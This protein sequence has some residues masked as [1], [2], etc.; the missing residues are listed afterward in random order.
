MYP[1][2]VDV[3][4]RAHWHIGKLG[5]FPVQ[6]PEVLEEE[7]F[8]RGKIHTKLLQDYS[9]YGSNMAGWQK[10]RHLTAVFTKILTAPTR[11]TRTPP[12]NHT[13]NLTLHVACYVTCNIKF[14]L[15]GN[16]KNYL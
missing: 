15:T 10:T 11:Q 14:L 12:F 5:N 2:D 13:L 16:K 9:I 7:E 4:T 6:G 3:L 8:T 1:T